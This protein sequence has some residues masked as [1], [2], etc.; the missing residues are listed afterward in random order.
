MLYENFSRSPQI[1]RVLFKSTTYCFQFFS[2]PEIVEL[3]HLYHYKITSEVIYETSHQENILQYININLPI[4]KL[5]LKLTK[6]QIK[7]SFP[8][9]E[10]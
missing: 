6:S 3:L 1:W 8:A 2:P 5:K 9:K 4:D 7:D 10:R